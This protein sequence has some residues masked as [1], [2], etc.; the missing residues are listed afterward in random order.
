M[1]PTTPKVCCRTTSGKKFKFVTDYKRHDWWNETYLVTW[2]CRQCY[3]QVYN[4][5]SK[6]LLFTRRRLQH[7]SIAS[8]MTLSFMSCQASSK[9]FFSS[10]ML[11]SCDWF[12]C[13]WM[14]YLVI[15]QIKVGTVRRPQIWRNESGCWLLK[16]SHRV[17]CPVCRFAVLLKDEEI[18]WHVTH[19]RQQLLWQEHVT[20]IATVDLHSR[21]D[22]D[23]VCEAK[24]WDAHGRRNRSTKCRPGADLQVTPV[25]FSH[26]LGLKSHSFSH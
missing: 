15:D 1:Y 16:K 17:A 23:E 18:V 13:C 2:F 6:C 9:R 24:L 22:K 5:C 8:S 25:S 14:S 4:S 21:T 19:H 11:C 7:L 20:V 26:S 12:T 3:C 10:S